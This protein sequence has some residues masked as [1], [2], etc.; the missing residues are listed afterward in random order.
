MID[1]SQDHP[2]KNAQCLQVVC[3]AKNAVCKNA[4]I[5]LIDLCSFY[6]V[7]SL[8]TIR[9]IKHCLALGSLSYTQ[10]S[11]NINGLLLLTLYF[12]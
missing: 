6:L 5:Q 12:L 2:E 1:L 9:Q 7:I 11:I 3:T 8:D 4:V 10:Y